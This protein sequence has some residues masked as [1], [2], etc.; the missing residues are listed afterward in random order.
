VTETTKQEEMP[1]VGLLTALSQMGEALKQKG[2]PGN[3]LAEARKALDAAI[4]EWAA[5][6]EE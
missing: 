5:G 2:E 6:E 1:S 3:R 4:L